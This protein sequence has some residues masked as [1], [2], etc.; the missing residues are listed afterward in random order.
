MCRGH[1]H[2][3]LDT[4]APLDVL[5][6]TAAYR[7]AAVTQQFLPSCSTVSRSLQISCGS[8]LARDSGGS[9]DEGGGCAAVIVSK[10]APTG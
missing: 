2:L 5:H 4:E 7:I 1:G 9:V 8:E 6:D 3:T 10:L